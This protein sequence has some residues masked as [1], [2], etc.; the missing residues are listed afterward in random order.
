MRSA[1][2]VRRI[3]SG[4]I[5]PAS[6]ALISTTAGPERVSRTSVCVG[7]RRMPVAARE[8]ATR[9]MIARAVCEGRVAGKTC[10]AS[11]NQGAP[12][13][14]FSEMPMQV[15]SPSWLNISTLSSGPSSSSSTSTV[16]VLGWPRTLAFTASS[17]SACA[18]ASAAVA[19][20]RTPCD[21]E[22]ST[23]LTTHGRPA[24]RV[25]SAASRGLRTIWN[26]GWATPA[27]ASAWRVAALLRH[28]RTACAGLPGKPR[29][30][31]SSATVGR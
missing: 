10:R 9:S 29:P 17:C 21:P 4:I 31:V 25:A 15:A 6:R 5:P 13:S 16:P 2:V 27:A 30:V 3:S 23:G 18:A 19:H 20:S 8:A 7:P 12:T 11:T 26:R 24:R 14:T 22:S 1:P 28:V